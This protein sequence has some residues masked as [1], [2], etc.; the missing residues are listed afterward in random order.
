MFSFV[1]YFYCLSLFVSLSSLLSFSLSL[2]LFISIPFCNCVFSYHTV[3]SSFLSY[4][5]LSLYLLIVCL[6][7][8]FFCL[9]F[10]VVFVALLFVFVYLLPYFLFSSSSTSFPFFSSRQKCTKLRKALRFKTLS[11]S[12]YLGVR[13]SQG[14]FTC[15]CFCV[16]FC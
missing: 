8:C 3:S 11:S 4:F 15:M 7:V 12:R 10:C 16:S 13:S 1:S 14:M 6:L 9:C 5:L 2:S